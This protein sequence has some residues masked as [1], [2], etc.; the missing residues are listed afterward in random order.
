MTQSTGSGSTRD[1]PTEPWERVLSLFLPTSWTLTHRNEV[2]G[3]DSPPW[4]HGGQV[5][6]NA[7]QIQMAGQRPPPAPPLWDHFSSTLRTPNGTSLDIWKTFF[8]SYSYKGQAYRGG[9]GGSPGYAGHGYVVM[10]I[11]LNLQ[12]FSPSDDS[13]LTK[14]YRQRGDGM[15]SL[16]SSPFFNDVASFPSFDVAFE[17]VWDIGS[18]AHNWATVFNSWAN[19]VNSEMSGW[20]GSAAGQF[21]AALRSFAKLLAD[22]RSALWNSSESVDLAIAE[23]RDSM[24][25]SLLALELAQRAW[26]ASGGLSLQDQ[27]WFVA[28]AFEHQIDGVED[29]TEVDENSNVIIGTPSKDPRTQGFWDAVSRRAK[30]MWLATIVQVLDPEATTILKDLAQR[31]GLTTKALRGAGIEPQPALTPPRTFGDSDGK[32][33]KFEDPTAVF[34]KTLKDLQDEHK[35]Q[36]KELTDEYNKNLK[37][38]EKTYRDRFTELEKGYKDQIAELT[39]KYNDLIRANGENTEELTNKFNKEIKD[40]QDGHK[41]QINEL[42][43]QYQEELKNLQDKYQKDLGNLTGLNNPPPGLT[44]LPQGLT[45]LP[46]GLSRN[47]TTDLPPGSVVVG[48]DGAPVLN[49]DGTLV[50]VPSRSTIDPDGTVIG[51]DGRP[52]LGPNGDPLVVPPASLFTPLPT[53]TPKSV[54]VGPDGSPVLGPGGTPLTVPP[55]SIIRP[56]GTV[57]GPDGRPVQG[58]N[59]GPLVVPPGSTLTPLPTPQSVVVGPDGSLVLNPDG[60]AL[61]VPPGSTIGPDGTVTGPDGRP[62]LGPGGEPLNVPPGSVLS[63]VG[64]PSPASVVVGPDGDAVLGP[65]GRVVTVPTGSTIGPDG[66][67]TGPDGR[68]VLGP[69]GDPIRVP[70]G[71]VLTPIPSG[72]TGLPDL[73]GPGAVLGD[74]DFGPIRVPITQAGSPL[75]PLDLPGTLTSGTQVASAGALPTLAA[76]DLALPTGLTGALPLANLHGGAPAGQEPFPFVPPMGGG[77]APGEQSRPRRSGYPLREAITP[78]RRRPSGGGSNPGS[79][80]PTGAGPVRRPAVTSEQQLPGPRGHTTPR[81]VGTAAAAAAANL[82]G[83]GNPANRRRDRNREKTNPYPTDQND[84]DVWG[85]DPDA[86]PGIIGR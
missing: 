26:E 80:N 77:G 61:T 73:R 10:G 84:D 20:Q 57:I 37:D 63:P 83:A 65:D 39:K 5:I 72:T 45:N 47:L 6:L 18:W 76:R 2:A 70:P 69:D 62:V 85:T 60:T 52:V 25:Y 42:Q 86:Q 16:I 58:P 24:R 35:K 53:L 43:A 79:P 38:L 81:G 66:T 32:P 8:V 9:G 50:T 22:L 68:P 74:P 71:S 67:V 59:G 19:D 55:G 34:N 54:V 31:Y 75:L 27:R 56:D 40:L 29:D 12:E 78:I 82:P 11:H 15:A 1:V 64:T 36:I 28:N 30:D 41:D 13:I 46:T 21:S 48:P 3:P 4:V 14:F 7:E 44:N 51:P 49:P 33:E 17:T 23:S